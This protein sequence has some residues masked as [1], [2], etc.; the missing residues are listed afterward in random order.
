MKGHIRQRSKGSWTIVIDVGRDPQTGKRRQQWH[1]VHGTKKDAERALR[2]LLQ[3][4]ETGGYVKPSR[5]TLGEWL[6]RWLESYVV[7]HVSPRTAES[8]KEQIR[9]HI[10]PALGTIPLA[11]LQAHHLEA[12]Y[13]RA[14]AQ[15][16]TDGKGG[17][18]PRTVRY[19][20]GLLFEALRHAV[21]QGFL[22]R[23]VVETVEPPRQSRSGKIAILTPEQV[24]KFLEVAQETP[25]HALFYTA[26]YTGMRRGELLGLRWCD[27][28]LELASLSVVQTLYKSRGSCIV[29]EPKSSYSRR[30]IALSPSLALL[31]RRHRA[32]QELRA[33]QLG[34]QLADADLVFSRLDGSAVDPSTLSH[35]FVKVVA[36][37]GL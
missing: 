34:R 20:H 27:V 30:S 28:D 22:M 14:L 13:A 23:N 33:R 35:T 18:S 29:K 1:T 17:L 36:K 24:A 7:M 12:H 26:V 5:L 37:A 32:E 11:Q 6:E 10:I 21:R 31:L 8:Y 19:Q 9:R 25:Y 2:E 4:V 16:R 15:G 3:A